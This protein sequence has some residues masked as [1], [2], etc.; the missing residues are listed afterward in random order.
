MRAGRLP[1]ERPLLARTAQDVAFFN[2]KAY[3]GLTLGRLG[4]AVEPVTA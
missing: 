3:L 1:D 4:E 2:A